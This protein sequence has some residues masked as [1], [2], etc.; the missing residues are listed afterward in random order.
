MALGH[1]GHVVQAI[2][3]LDSPAGHE[4]IVDHGLAAGAAFL[5]RLEDHHRGSVEIAR[6]GKIFRSTQQHGGVAVMAAGMHQARRLGCVG[7]A[8]RLRDRQCVHVRTQSDG[9]AGA[10]LAAADHADDAGAPNATHDI[11]ASEFAQS[12]GDD[13]GRAMHFV[14]QF[15]MLVEIMPPGG[16][17]VREGGDA[18]DDG[19]VSIRFLQ[20]SS[21]RSYVS[22]NT[23][24]KIVSTCLK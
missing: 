13:A 21:L 18:V 17:V 24:L 11:V 4:P 6:F 22:P 16:H 9:F 12:V 5:G 8:R 19:H 7:Y 3:L 20:W 10:A 15:R 1:A 2:D 23:R 14:Q